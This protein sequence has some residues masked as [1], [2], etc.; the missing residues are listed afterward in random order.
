MPIR[1]DHVHTTAAVERRRSPYPRA[2]MV[3]LMLALA[4]LTVPQPAAAGPA[5]DAGA[6]AWLLNQTRADHGLS[7]LTPDY[8]LQVL[9]NR[10]ANRMAESGSIFHTANLGGRLSWGWQGWAENVGYGPSVGWV[11]GAFMNSWHHSS[12]ILNPSFNYVGVG[13]AY[14]NDGNVYVAQV[15]GSW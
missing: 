11:H 3:A 10:Q 8:E 9:A 1:E 15:F 6:A 7:P 4:V 12:N 14:G 13:V 5:E 2:L